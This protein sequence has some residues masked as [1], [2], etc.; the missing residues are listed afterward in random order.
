MKFSTFMPAIALALV[1]GPAVAQ[2]LPPSPIRMLVGFA[3]GGGNDVIARTLSTQLQL[4]TKGTV[5][6]E[7]KPGGG[8]TLATA[9][10]ARA[11]P[12][13]QTLLLGS[14]GGQAIA[15]SIYSKLPTIRS[16]AY[17]PSRWSPGPPMPWW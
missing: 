12:N 13:G 14:V 16:R 9:E 4:Q 10:M 1:T 6:V 2:E 7:N 17:R 3:P 15:P 11:K 5:V 8:S